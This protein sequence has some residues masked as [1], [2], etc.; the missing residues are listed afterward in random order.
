MSSTEK[1]L[2]LHNHLIKEGILWTADNGGGVIAYLEPHI[3]DI[4]AMIDELRA[5]GFRYKDTTI[6]DGIHENSPKSTYINTTSGVYVRVED[7]FCGRDEKKGRKPTNRK[8][9]EEKVSPARQSKVA[10]IKKAPDKKENDSPNTAAESTGAS[11]IPPIQ[12]AA[13]QDKPPEE[14]EDYPLYIEKKSGRLLLLLQPSLFEILKAQAKERAPSVNAYIHTIL[15]EATEKERSSLSTNQPTTKQENPPEGY[16]L[17]PLFIET[18]SK[19]LQLLLQ[20]S[21]LEEIRLQAK[22]RATSVNAYVH[23][24]LNKM[25]R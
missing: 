9:S 1:D 10:S 6:F 11:P 23:T 5:V 13:I 18:K 17:N 3:G 16:K 12:P 21:L 7:A 14:N 4:Q 22:E 20:P 15:K 25:A 24:I 8:T 2:Q 19:R